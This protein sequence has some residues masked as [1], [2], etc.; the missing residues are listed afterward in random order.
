MVRKI[1]LEQVEGI[2]KKVI[3]ESVYEGLSMEDM[4]KGINYIGGNLAYEMNDREELYDS[5][6]KEDTNFLWMIA[7]GL[8]AK[9]VE[10]LMTGQ[11][12]LAQMNKWTPEK[13]EENMK[14]TFD[15]LKRIYQKDF[16]DIKVFSGNDHPKWIDTIL[17]L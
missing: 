5:V 12:S 7:D 13:I 14:E 2:V 3:N 4:L 11:T 9:W 15:R 6:S 16:K 1:T 17:G 8:Y 10:K